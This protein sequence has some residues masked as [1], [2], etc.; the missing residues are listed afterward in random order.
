M[1]MRLETP[2]RIWAR[3][4]QAQDEELPSLPSMPA[5]EDSAFP[6]E[7]EA[8]SVEHSAYYPTPAK[9][10]SPSTFTPT[11]RPSK[12]RALSTPR[13]VGEVTARAPIQPDNPRLGSPIH[14]H[15]LSMDSLPEE[16]L[17]PPTQDDE[18]LSMSLTDALESI[19]RTGSPDE[20]EHNES[21]APVHK[22]L[23]DIYNDSHATARDVD[24]TR[25]SNG[26]SAHIKPSP[27][28]RIPAQAPSPIPTLTHSPR[29]VTSASSQHTPTLQRL[30]LSPARGDASYG[31][32]SDRSHRSAPASRSASRVA[33]SLDSERD[34]SYDSLP[35]EPSQDRSL[36]QPSRSASVLERSLSQSKLSVRPS[37]KAPQNEAPPAS[38]SEIT[39]DSVSVHSFSRSRS[40]P[41]QRAASETPAPAPSTS[42]F[43][44]TRRAMTA[45]PAPSPA[46]AHRLPVPQTPGSGLDGALSDT[47]KP[48]PGTS[49][50]SRS[51]MMQVVN[52]A[53]QPTLRS[54]PT[55]FAHSRFQTPA[56]RR[57]SEAAGGVGSSSFVS[58]AS[59]HDLAI[60]RRANASF[61]A[62]AHAR[63][64]GGE[65]DQRK[66]RTYLQS[67]NKHLSE[68]NAIYRD[69]NVM[70]KR[71][72]L[73]LIER[74]AARGVK[75]DRNA[76][77]EGLSIDLDMG[78]DGV[79]RDPEI[80]VVEDLNEELV[81]ALNH[82][83]AART[84][85]DAIRSELEAAQ[86][87]ANAA[88]EEVAQVTEQCNAQI[89][90]LET[91]VQHVI[92]RMQGKLKEREAEAS[93]L[94]ER[95]IDRSRDGREAHEEALMLEREQCARLE[96]QVKELEE[97]I[98]NLGAE[99]RSLKAELRDARAALRNEQVGAT[100]AV[101]KIRALEKEAIE[102]ETK[103]QRLE[104]DLEEMDALERERDEIANERDDALRE[105][106]MIA[107]ERDAAVR[108]QE[109]ILAERDD[110]LHQRN[111]A[112]KQVE[113]LE[114]ALE[115][116]ESRILD[117]AE[118]I[119]S[120]R[121]KITS[122][123]RERTELMNRSSRSRS[124]TEDHI[125]LHEHEALVADLERQLDDAHREI[126]RLT[127][128]S[129]A[130]S[131]LAKAK[132]MRIE[133]LEKEKEVL[134]ERIQVM[135]SAGFGAGAGG[136][137]TPSRASFTAGTANGTPLGR[138]AMMNLKTPKTPGAALRDPSWLNQSTMHGLTDP[139]AIHARLME[140]DARLAEAN[141]SIDDKLD[142]L[143][144]AGAGTVSLTTNLH[145]AKEKITSLERELAHLGRRE[146]RLIKKLQRCRCAKCHMRF[147]ASAI[148]QWAETSSASLLDDLMTEPPTPETKTSRN[149]QVALAAA[150]AQLESLRAEWQKLGQENEALRGTSRQEAELARRAEAEMKRAMEDER[151]RAVEAA[152]SIKH[153]KEREKALADME[154][155]RARNAIA[156]L[157]E[158]LRVERSKLRSLSAEHSRAT[159][160][161]AEVLAKLERTNLDVD[162]VKSQLERYKN[163]NKE[164]EM[165]L[166]SNALAETKARHLEARLQENNLQIENLRAEREVLTRDHEQLRK[167]FEEV[168]ERA[169]SLRQR[170]ANSQAE[171]DKRQHRLDM[172]VTEIEALRALLAER[173]AGM[174]DMA[175]AMHTARGAQ[176]DAE[177]VVR[178]LQAELKRVK[179]EADQLGTDIE[180]LKSERV[181]GNDREKERQHRARTDAQVQMRALNEQL[182]SAKDAAAQLQIRL[183]DHGA[184]WRPEQIESLKKTHNKECK[185]LMVQIRYLK[186]K[187]YRESLLRQ[188]VSY[189]KRYLIQVLDVY[190]KPNE[191]IE[192]ALAR[193]GFPHE[194]PPVKSRK[195]LKTVA[196]A[197]LF[198]T[199][200]KRLSADWR[201]KRK[202][203]PAIN[204]AL[205]EVR[206]HRTTPS[207]K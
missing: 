95:L 80:E 13:S 133:Q 204:A 12:I 114:T 104:Q 206:R 199:R 207:S 42:P 147:D 7:S 56:V 87:D 135:R 2:S 18:E 127:A 38:E 59:S 65:F 110:L 192:R 77:F 101:D 79:E 51:F 84:E 167:R 202:V 196:T 121:G 159:R 148:V 119:K 60:H 132:D 15:E 64:G 108:E 116:V 201:E 35:K 164:L 103:V 66:L 96:H 184:A 137:G 205:E 155:D 68:E 138:L 63:G 92:E 98:A 163:N 200:A 115:T 170:N 74:L 160:D 191:K 169:E 10:K 109:D 11:P 183:K 94:R 73:E 158:E 17:P 197:I 1:A 165:E 23:K 20:L 91:D 5:F 152:K 154:L 129:P 124:N 8:V 34:I 81:T 178:A 86:A 180:H 172:Q 70:L 85:V 153:E 156:E 141:E 175:A 125:P 27:R 32:V 40:S 117:D 151:R 72:C 145:V 57:L 105:R 198:M 140:V 93:E 177:R 139:E 50:L 186:D 174:K 123:E 62:I 76:L 97:E 168:T 176:S 189:Q 106:D 28:A 83:E 54:K 25:R 120:L 144:K 195:S 118:Q 187:F 130:G 53:V 131:A 171:H 44:P 43:N 24:V 99:G 146:E 48:A 29:S 47:P 41:G 21:R 89:A 52:S 143:E 4:E 179:T 150:N 126:A 75:V 173:E 67:L 71:A 19:S 112:R 122:L 61:D 39:Y 33:Q 134:T 100:D 107:K 182:Q 45:S 162:S 3:I 69:E 190:S 22:S 6:E 193:P 111:E 78:E 58:T 113:E 142:K 185:G 149:L 90:E 161:K 88:R 31:S 136:A 181:E 82:A 102:W 128:E 188:D 194:K 16:Y 157:E 203:K 166:R 49:K 37:P 14:S 9:A 55:P 46:Q 26:L 36:A 30:P